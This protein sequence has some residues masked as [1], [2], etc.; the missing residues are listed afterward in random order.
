MALPATAAPAVT[1]DEMTFLP[2]ADYI[3]FLNEMKVAYNAA[4]AS[5]SEPAHQ[6]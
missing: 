3:R 4:L 5:A 2:L 6:R 1:F